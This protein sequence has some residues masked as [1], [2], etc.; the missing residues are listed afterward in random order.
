VPGDFNGDG[1]VNGD[2]LGTLL[3][4]WGACAS[5]P[6]DLNGDGFVDGNDL[7]QLLGLWTL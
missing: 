4:N 3:A 7:G 1:V 6:A 5:C 2:D